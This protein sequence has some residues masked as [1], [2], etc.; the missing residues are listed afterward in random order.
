M[1]AVSNISNVNEIYN[2]IIQKN[3][4][5]KTLESNE[6]QNFNKKDYFSTVK[7]ENYDE[8]DYSR[9]LNKFKQIDQNI[10][11]HEQSHAAGSSYSSTPKYNYAQGPDGKLYAVGGEVRLDT[12]MPQ[13]KKAALN[14]LEEISNASNAPHDVSSADANITRAANL[15]KMLLHSS[16]KEETDV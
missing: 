8:V 3:S 6:Q 9:V 1:T 12:S 5:L 16:L 7:S 15:N 10:R 4:E 13:D 14:K 11:S 2:R